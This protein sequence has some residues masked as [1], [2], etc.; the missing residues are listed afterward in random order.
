MSESSEFGVPPEDCD[1]AAETYVEPVSASKRAY[2]SLIE[3][4]NVLRCDLQTLEA[5]NARLM[6]QRN[7]FKSQLLRASSNLDKLHNERS[8][9]IAERDKAYSE[10]ERLGRECAELKAFADRFSQAMDVITGKAFVISAEEAKQIAVLNEQVSRIREAQSQPKQR[11]N[12][13][14]GDVLGMLG[15]AGKRVNDVKSA[16]A[17]AQANPLGDLFD[18]D[19]MEAIRD[20]LKGQEP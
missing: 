19:K 8:Q 4:N 16:P 17:R 6:A 18:H 13:T 20:K 14:I 1:E 5:T 11:N 3:E 15:N 10:I 9:V 12:T 7:E 2:N